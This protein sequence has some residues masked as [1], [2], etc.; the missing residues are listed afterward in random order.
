MHASISVSQRAKVVIS[1][2]ANLFLL[3][4]TFHLTLH[5]NEQVH[6]YILAFDRLANR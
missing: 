5:A 6:C 2:D 1:T 3:T 4:E